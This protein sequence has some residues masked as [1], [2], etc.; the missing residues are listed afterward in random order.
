[1]TAPM[2]VC[3]AVSVLIATII[4]GCVRCPKTHVSMDQLV[5]EHNANALIVPRIWARVK[6]RMKFV[7]ESGRS[8]R[9]GSLSPLVSPNGKLLLSKTDDPLGAQ[10][11]VLIGSETLGMDLFRLGSSASEGVYY[12]WVRLGQTGKAW[13]GRHEFAG[14]PGLDKT[15]PINPNQLLSVLTVC[16]LP[17]DFTQLPTVLMRMSS[18]P[19]AYVL[20]YVDRQ[21]LTGRIIARKDIYY[22]WDDTKPRRPFLVKLFG[23]DGRELVVAQLKNYRQIKTDQDLFTPPVM[24]TDIKIT[25]TETGNQIRLIL[26]EMTTEDKWDT[27][28]CRFTDSQTGALPPGISPADIVQVDKVLET[29]GTI[30]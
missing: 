22:T 20:T 30:H 5:A 11:F 6:I 26:S 12:L 19:C 28:A 4:T 29:E 7:D 2:R 25:W 16:I 23:S 21:V 8:W 14:A 17:N 27:E 13:W 3:F 10:D 9:W 24:P 1:M 18:N 15:I